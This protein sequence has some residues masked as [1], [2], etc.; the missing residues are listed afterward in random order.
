MRLVQDTPDE[1]VEVHEVSEKENR[2]H[3]G[4]II[5]ILVHHTSSSALSQHRC[6]G[7]SLLHEGH[8]I[9]LFST[10]VRLL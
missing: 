4:T 1:I 9:I 10:I 2:L 5:L 3:A 6:F 7:L 8:F